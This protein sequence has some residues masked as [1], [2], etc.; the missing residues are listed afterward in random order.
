MSASLDIRQASFLDLCPITAAVDELASSGG[1]DERG[2]V[3][4][5]PEVVGFIL[6]LCGY[7]ADKP[8]WRSRL[9]EPSF[10]GGDFILPIIDRLLASWRDTGSGDALGELGDS[11]R[12]VELHKGT[13]ERTRTAVI[14]ALEAAGLSPAA[15]RILAGQWLVHGDYLLTRLE[16]GFDFVVGN[17]PYV[18]QEL[19][20]GVLLA[21]YRARYRTLYDRADLYI[22]FIEKSLSVL[23]K[24]G[25][26][27]FICADRWMKNKYGGPL[28]G[29]VASNFHLKVYVDMT[30]TPAFHADVIAY[31]AITVIA[32]EKP[33]GT[34]VAHR[35]MIDAAA[36]AALS[37]ALTA[38][39]IPAG[40]AVREIAG[41]TAESAPWILDSS[42][43]MAL[44]RRLER[45][46]PALEDAQCKVGIGVATGADQAFIG[47]YAELD[48]EDDRKL[49]LAM[50]RD[51]QTGHVVWRG[52]GVVN[53]FIDGPGSG[54]VSLDDYPRLRR[55]LES[56]K[57][58]IAGRHVAL[59][60]PQNWYRTIDRI[61]SSLASRPKLLIPD[62]KGKAQIVYEEGR[63]YPHHNLYYV[64]SDVWELKALQAVL[65]SDVA[66]LFVASYSTKMR[67]G[68]LRFQAQYLRRIRV[69][70]W[71]DVSPSLR[72]ELQAAA[73]SL[74][75]DACNRA[76]FKAY[77]LTPSEQS[78][79]T[80]KDN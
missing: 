10:G 56:R 29:Y 70:Q 18:R 58:E 11:L 23:N 46:F 59:K 51:I 67:G 2:A 68:F 61:T 38:P 52:F 27:G 15:S 24:G 62:I 36:L 19:I 22:P 8:I 63:L 48:V 42:A 14:L 13:F 72:E 47:P 80:G 45:D 79:L 41:V 26:L 30:D 21:E 16:S 3:F 55:Y 73:E 6:D 44:L 69:P 4:T 34:R 7:K 50:T 37:H 32:N 74:D 1:S 39:V 64:T 35:P 20:P 57:A 60:A 28:R 78:A 31:P 17:P 25:V 75:M 5:R 71:A 65:L 77:K 54:L 76:A 33:A 49:P 9:L 53:P 43:Q 66:R 12:A 40:S